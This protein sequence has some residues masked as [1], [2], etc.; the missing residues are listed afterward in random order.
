MFK[1]EYRKKNRI[2]KE[3]D[4]N[5]ETSLEGI[6]KTRQEMI[7]A[8]SRVMAVEVVKRCHILAVL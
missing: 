3:K 7:V 1:I 2:Q 4:R 5:T 6:A 8:W